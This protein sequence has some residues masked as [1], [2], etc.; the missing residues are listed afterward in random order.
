MR[1]RRDAGPRGL[2]QAFDELRFGAART[3]N[4]RESLPTAAEA[5]RRA[6]S[7]LREQHMQRAGEVLV[8]TGRGNSSPGGRSVVREATQRV[9]HELRRKGVVARFTEHTPGSFAVA[10]A[11][12]S[13]LFEAA[14]R[15]REKEPLP[16]PATPPTL[17][18]LEPETR[19]ALRAL[20]ECSLHAL[21]VVDRTPFI[22]GEMLKLFGT[23]ASSIGEG[24]ER[25]RRLRA[26]IAA[27][28]EEYDS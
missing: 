19:E 23:L 21:G 2:E 26:A 3:L 11:P 8:I 13:A 28:M 14:R 17:R 12:V 6:E 16:A 10:L 5:A 15:R 20:A 9:L 24:P 22:Q 25:E 7:W 18:S 27:A 4:L 1:D